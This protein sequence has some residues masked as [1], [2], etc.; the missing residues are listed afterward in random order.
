MQLL[1]IC[2]V[3]II[4]I[5]SKKCSSR[6]AAERRTAAGQWS[7]VRR[8]MKTGGEMEQERRMRSVQSPTGTWYEEEASMWG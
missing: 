8:R 2:M 4:F 5:N 6:K 7:G 1:I 3:S